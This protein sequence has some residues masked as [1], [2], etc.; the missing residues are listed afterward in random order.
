LLCPIVSSRLCFHFIDFQEPFNFLFYFI[1]DP[2]FI[3]QWVLQFLAVCMFFIFT[4][5]VSSTFNAFWS[6]KIHG[7]IS[8]FLYLLRLTFCPKIWSILEKVPWA[9]QKNVCCVEVGWNVLQTSTRS[10]WSMICFRSRISLLTFCLDD[11][12]INDNEVLKSLT[13]TVLEL[14]YDFSSFRVCLMKLGAYRLINVISFWSIFPFISMEYSSL[15]C[16][17]NVGLKST[18]SEINIAT[19]ACF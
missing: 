14:I 7:M 8:I 3:N 17:S 9:S 19:P 4:F 15:S 6:E 13:T 11:L 1:N 2:L 5:V 12:S 10:I 16:L 18:L